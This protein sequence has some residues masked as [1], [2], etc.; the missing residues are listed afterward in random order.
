[1]LFYVTE[2]YQQQVNSLLNT[3]EETLDLKKKTPTTPS[4]K[5]TEPLLAN[6]LR[7]G[8]MNN[9]TQ[10]TEPERIMNHLK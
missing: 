3:F 10:I 7:S 5:T 8:I 4:E 2:E 1:M 9:T 6:L